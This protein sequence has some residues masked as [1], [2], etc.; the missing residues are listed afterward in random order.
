MDIGP[1]VG[2]YEVIQVIGQGGMG[3]VFLGHD[4]E[5]DT[6]IAIK[7]LLQEALLLDPQLLERLKREGEALRRLNHPNIV[8]MLDLIEL[9]NEY[10]IILEYVEGGSLL[11]LIRSQDQLPLGYILKVSLELADALA[12]A[13]HLKI[14]HRD[15]KPANI[16]LAQD[17]SPRLTDFGVARMESEHTLTQEGSVV[18]SAGYMSPE[19]IEGQV[20][21]IR[22]DIWAFGVVLF[23][24]LAGQRLFEGKTPMETLYKIM[25]APLPDITT[26]RDDIPPALA[27]LLTQLLMRDPNERIGSMRR[28]GADLEHIIAALP[29]DVKEALPAQLIQ[30]TNEPS[31]FSTPTPFTKTPSATRKRTA[32]GTIILPTTATLQEPTRVLPPEELPG[33]VPPRRAA[34]WGYGVVGIV[35]L[36]AILIGGWAVFGQADEADSIQ[37]ASVVVPT[38]EPVPMGE[39][40][41]L[42]AQLEAF[43]DPNPNLDR[44]LLDDL[45][46]K[47][48]T[49]SANTG[50]RVRTYGAPIRSPEEALQVGHSNGAV[51]IVW[52]NYS[53]DLIEINVQALDPV[54]SPTQFVQEASLVTLHLTSLRQESVAEQVLAANQMWQAY[55][56]DSFAGSNALVALDEIEKQ[57]GQ[58]QGQ[59]VGAYSHRYFA[60][61]FDDPAAAAEQLDSALTISPSNPLLYHLRALALSNSGQTP[62]D[63][64]STRTALRLSNGEW[65]SPYVVLANIEFNRGNVEGAVENYQAY[66]DASPNDWLI[67]TI[68]GATQYLQGDYA[69]ARASFE[70]SISQNPQTNFPY[71]YM[72]MLEVRQGNLDQVNQAL[73]TALQRFPDPTLGNRL[74]ESFIGQGNNVNFF[75][76]TVAAFGSLV[77]G[78]YQDATQSAENALQFRN[79]MPEIY[80]LK[81]VAQCLGGDYA[82]AEESYSQGLA[83]DSDFT[84]L[85]LLRADVRNRQNKL[86]DALLD[87]SAAQETTAWPNFEETVSAALASGQAL[88]CESFFVVQ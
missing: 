27:N 78:Q 33:Y 10:A 4:R 28:V 81:G 34:H 45:R 19:M 31:R 51:V 29:P 11:D 6:P 14:I 76:E 86:G 43:D 79:D 36:L 83:L 68:L 7:V 41:V 13:H 58:I 60:L 40:M 32:S 5:S 61:F 22:A 37:P 12:R 35:A 47:L 38:V 67:L 75:G 54:T 52:G 88:G 46:P 25:T 72:M 63:E 2:P 70:A 23:E 1:L 18:G 44:F 87:F 21:D 30:R 55:Y 57:P 69:A 84:T 15:L 50:L 17:G 42:V 49:S 20:V 85:Y 56:G 74:L 71:L 73:A 3:K 66:L 16:L 8:K 48:E 82:G 53:A 59:T 39:F 77:L 62:A 24:M 65:K 80:M 9:E 64:E 26:L